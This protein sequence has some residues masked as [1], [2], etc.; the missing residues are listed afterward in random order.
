MKNKKG[1]NMQEIITHLILILLITT[2][3]ILNLSSK[4]DSRNVKQ[5]ILEKQT[6][7]LIDS[8]IPGMSFIIQKNNVNGYINKIE[9]KENK[10]FVQIDGLVSVNGYPI[11]TQH[12]VQL[13]EDSNQNKYIIQIT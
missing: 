7:L 6:A 5:Q 2:L 10:I 13:I 9:I 8:A 3:F 11:L 4:I 12:N 1:T